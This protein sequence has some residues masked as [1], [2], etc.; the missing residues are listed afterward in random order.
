[1]DNPGVARLLDQVADLLEIKGEANPFRIRSYRIAAE[2]VEAHGEPVG[3]MD[4]AALKNRLGVGSGMAARIQEIVAT[5]DCSARQKLLEEIP[6][7]LLE[8]LKISGLGPKGVHKIWHGLAV[9]SADELLA[10]I[11]D[12]RFET[13]PGMGKKKAERIRGG[14]ERLRE[15]GSTS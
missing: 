12:G 2:A 15:K 6:A 11:D 5:G 1:M 8:L 3:G 10:A 13:L 4:E 7:G 9:R 14:I